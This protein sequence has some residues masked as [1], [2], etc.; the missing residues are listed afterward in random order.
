VIQR[1]ELSEAE[2][3]R[4]LQKTAMDTR[5]TMGDVAQA[6]LLSDQMNHLRPVNH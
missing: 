2:A 3:Y 4:R 6:L 5:K 1:L